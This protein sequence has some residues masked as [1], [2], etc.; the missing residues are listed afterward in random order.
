[1]RKNFLL[2]V[3]ALTV[4]ATFVTNAQVYVDSLGI[5]QVGNYENDFYHGIESW[6]KDTSIVLNVKGYGQVFSGA[7]I[8][9]GDNGSKY[10]QNV[11]I[12][13]LKK[14]N[15]DTDQ[16]W[17]QGKKGI[18]FTCA[19]M[20]Q[21]TVFYYDTN[22][23]NDFH[24]NCNVL[25]SN[26]AVAS[27]SRFKTDIAPLESSLQTITSLSP[28]SYKLLPRFGENAF[29]GNG[30]SDD[31]P[32]GAL[33]EKELRDIEYFNKFHQSL[34]NDGPHFG[35]IAQEVK[36]IYP[37]LVHTDKDGYMYIDYIGMIPLLV[38]AIG[39]LNTQIEEQNA[40][41]EEL[42]ADN[43]ELSQAVINAQSPAIGNNQSSQI[44]DDFFRNALYQ[45]NPNPFST[46]TSIAMSLRS[47]VIQAVVYIFD[48]QGNMLRTIPVND[49]GNVSVTI[50]GGDL[51]AGMY[52]YSLI[53]DGKE[54]ASKRM[55]LTK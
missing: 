6:S 27:D 1:M 38:N 42:R 37:E 45:N 28:V 43:S 48:M 9:I 34:E 41:I 46:S 31:I 26:I 21:D 52:I 40:Q 23:G 22:R 16:M 53:A 18:Y 10:A 55:I 33:T 47:D 19:N 39:E 2:I 51:N 30:M 54:I 32:T 7:K 50:E 5:V 20:S 12:G 14:G 36:E 17:L 35:F 11:S 44:A 4:C 8:A 49:R 13:E 25:A 29:G 3:C 24:F 15:G